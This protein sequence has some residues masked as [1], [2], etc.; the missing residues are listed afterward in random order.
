[1][2]LDSLRAFV[3]VAE[4]GQ[5]RYAA[6]RLRLSQQAVSKRVAALES[7]LGVTLFERVPTGA[8]LTADGRT[9]LPHAHAVLIAARHAV[10]SVQRVARPLRVDILGAR[11]LPGVLML[12]FHQAH[13]EIALKTLVLRG[14]GAALPALLSGEIDATFAYHPDP[15]PAGV[16]SMVAYLEPHEIVVGAGHPLADRAAV[17]VDE[18][19]RY[20]FWIPG[21]VEGSEWGAFYQELSAEF[22]LTIDSTGPN[23]GFEDLIATIAESRSLVTFWGERTREL[24]PWPRGLRKLRVV[25]PTPVYPWSLIWLSSNR[26]P[27]LDT[28]VEH[29]RRQPQPALDELWL[30]ERLRRGSEHHG[31][32]AGL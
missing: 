15:L 19:R 5:F 1:M 4:E 26:H 28:L 2:N 12:D 29:V 3:A 21:I 10:E 18:L 9:F 24:G 31:T 20:T 7:S 6:D 22:G 14:L 25:E 16:E 8:V 32:S 23:F 17:P 11:L 13:P 27:D 30:P